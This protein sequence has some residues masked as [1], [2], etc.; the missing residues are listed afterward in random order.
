[1]NLQLEQLGVSADG[2]ERRA[3][4][5]AHR[6]E[7]ITL[8]TICR[9]GF[10]AG[11]LRNTSARDEIRHIH[12]HDRDAFDA[13]ILIEQGMIH[14]VEK[15][16]FHLAGPAPIQYGAYFGA[17]ERHTGREDTIQQ[18]VDSLARELG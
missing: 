18:L 17:D 10:I 5:V 2:V 8:R 9:F 11:R 1:V 16:L 3:Q 4:L 15:P 13:A 14:Q 6:R 12:G 7:E